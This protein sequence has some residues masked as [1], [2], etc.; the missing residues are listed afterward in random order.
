[1]I[2]EAAASP[3]GHNGGP[4]LDAKSP[5]P[6]L[7]AVNFPG[8]CMGASVLMSL[9][10][11]KI[12]FGPLTEKEG[13]ALTN[14]LLNVVTAFEVSIGDKRVAAVLDLSG[15]LTAILLPRIM[16]DIARRKARNASPTQAAANDRAEADVAQGA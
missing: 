8:I 9:G 10:M 14:S 4:A 12:G 15:T 13:E 5:E 7:T 1:M 3:I 16:D 11:S 2:A 6:A